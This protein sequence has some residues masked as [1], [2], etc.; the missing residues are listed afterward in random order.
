MKFVIPLFFII[1]TINT[2]AQKKDVQIRESSLDIS[3]RN[4]AGKEFYCRHKDRYILNKECVIIVKEKDSKRSKPG[5]IVGI[6][7]GFKEKGAF[8][9][10]YKHGL[11]KTVFKS[12]VV[13]M[14][15]WNNGLIFGAYKVFTT[16]GKLLYEMAFSKNGT[17]R[18]KDYYYKTGKLKVEGNYTKGRKEGPWYY[19]SEKGEKTN[20]IN[21][22]QGTP[23]AVPE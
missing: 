4:K 15:N 14:E 22:K 8:K 17:S 21:Y 2:H 11:W 1:L 6:S 7:T 13:K 9:L 5:K 3:V 23:N 19:Y 18:Y 12:K 20:T 10:G 16:K